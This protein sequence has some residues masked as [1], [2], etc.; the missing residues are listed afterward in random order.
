M[1][2]GIAGAFAL[3][4]EGLIFFS[5]H[6][7][8]TVGRMGKVGRYIVELLTGWAILMS[9]VSVV[10]IFVPLLWPNKIA[11]AWCV[12]LGAAFCFLVANFIVWNRE[13]T[14]FQQGQNRI[15]ELTA[16][17]LN[18]AGV[19]LP[20][21]KNQYS[22]TTVTGLQYRIEIANISEALSVQ[23][24]EVKLERIIPDVPQL[25]LPVWLQQMHD[26][27]VVKQTKFDLNPNSR[28][29]ID[30]VLNRS[31]DSGMFICQTVAGVQNRISQG[32]YVVTISATGKDAIGDTKKFRIDNTGGAFHCEMV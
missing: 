31:D 1:S 17:K 5:L 19:I 25:R 28:K 18:I 2:E 15:K 9:T 16:R 12:W 10:L 7:L 27:A 8:E 24:I 3:L 23:D 13:N 29:Q 26:N 32:A 6:E 11:P 14:K 20:P 30:L 4:V 21:Q 22:G